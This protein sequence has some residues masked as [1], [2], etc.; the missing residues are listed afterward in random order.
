[1][2]STINLPLCDF[3]RECQVQAWKNHKSVC[4]VLQEAIKKKEN[5][6]KKE[7]LK[8]KEAARKKDATKKQEGSKRNK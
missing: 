3:R 2:K 7:A 1:M 8:K 4:D 6:K 5:D